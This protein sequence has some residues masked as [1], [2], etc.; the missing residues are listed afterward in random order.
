[1]KTRIGKV[2]ED[3]YFQN[4]FL[5]LLVLLLVS[6]RLSADTDISFNSISSRDEEPLFVV[7]SDSAVNSQDR[8]KLNISAVW[9][10]TSRFIG[11]GDLPDVNNDF[12][13]VAKLLD[14]AG[15]TVAA[16][17]SSEENVSLNFLNSLEVV[18]F[19]IEFAPAKQ[20]TLGEEYYV[21]CQ[22]QYQDEVLI[23]GKLTSIWKGIGAVEN[24]AALEV[25]HFVNVASGDDFH[26]IQAHINTVGM[27]RDYIVNTDSDLASLPVFLSVDVARWDDFMASFRTDIIPFTIDFDLINTV[28][29]DSLPL[30]NDGIVNQ[31]ININNWTTDGTRRIPIFTT[32]SVFAEITP[33]EQ[34]NSVDDQY[35]LRATLSHLENPVTNSEIVDSVGESP[36]QRILHFNGDI[37]FGSVT[38]KIVDLANV[39]AVGVINA[40]V[41]LETSVILGAEGGALDSRPDL[42]F[43]GLSFSHDVTLDI[44]GTA[45]YVGGSLAV[46]TKDGEE[47]IT[48]E[49]GGMNYSYRA[50]LLPSVAL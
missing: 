12:R 4:Y 2:C 6:V 35:V 18:D 45:S 31:N 50:P 7:D 19:Q 1:M 36:S 25:P 15:N 38:G 32:R 3:S 5:I 8:D 20:L 37:E 49:V 13:V 22:L 21:E 9:R 46:V 26:N 24:S 47:V 41:N 39:P 27:N 40:G 33:S 23:G 16:F 14:S 17:T 43:G 44:N 48:E 11:V 42:A 28:T 34:I 29:N 10:F 30:V